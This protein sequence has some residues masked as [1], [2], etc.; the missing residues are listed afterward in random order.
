MK[1]LFILLI[2]IPLLLSC[3]STQNAVK[4]TEHAQ[5]E[6]QEPS[7]LL[8]ESNKWILS[9]FNGQSPL[10]AGFS[11]R[12]PHL[13]INLNENKI[14]GYSGCNSF[15]GKATVDKNSIT[16]SQ[17]FSTKMFCQGVP[18]SEFFNLLSNTL[19]YEIANNTLT[20]RKDG[21]PLMKFKLEGK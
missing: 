9:E 7:E 14:G 8:T 16:F 5:V 1:T 13:V 11:K 18:E 2:S 21:K 3:K 20:L 19:E 15:G 4:K 17:I 10:D 6:T 12:L